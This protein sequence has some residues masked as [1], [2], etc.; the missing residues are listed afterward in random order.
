MKHIIDKLLLINGINLI[1][2]VKQVLKS[3]FILSSM[4]EILPPTFNEWQLCRTH[5]YDENYDSYTSVYTN[6][7]GHRFVRN[8][9]GMNTKNDRIGHMIYHSTTDGECIITYILKEIILQF[10]NIDNIYYNKTIIY[11]DEHGHYVSDIVPVYYF[12]K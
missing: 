2:D 5:E 7:Y 4:V 8:I 10:V 1:D 9:Y 3:V 11:K 6:E 12:P